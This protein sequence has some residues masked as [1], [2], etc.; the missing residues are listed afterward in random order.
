MCGDH[1]DVGTGSVCHRYN[2][3]KAFV[4]GQWT[5]KID[6]YAIASFIR[7]RKGV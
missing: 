1:L 5:N 6:R 2:A 4:L 3:V 7:N